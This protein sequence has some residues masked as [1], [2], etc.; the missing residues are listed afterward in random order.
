MFAKIIVILLKPFATPSWHV[1][2]CKN[3]VEHRREKIPESPDRCVLFM[4]RRQRKTKVRHP[5]C[6]KATIPSSTSLVVYDTLPENRPGPKRIEMS[7]P[8]IHF[9]VLC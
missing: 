4:S 1:Q 6:F 9:Q 5:S 3:S 7:I 2:W 8:T